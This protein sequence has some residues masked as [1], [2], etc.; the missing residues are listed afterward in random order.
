MN[1]LCSAC[2]IPE[3]INFEARCGHLYHQN[4]IKELSWIELKCRVCSSKMTSS[5]T[6]EK[7][8]RCPSEDEQ[9]KFIESGLPTKDLQAALI[10]S[11][12]EQNI[13]LFNLLLDRLG[14]SGVSFTNEAEKTPL[15]FAAEVGNVEVVDRL[16]NMKAKV[17]AAEKHFGMTPLILACK[18][19]HSDVFDRLLESG[20]NLN[21]KCDHGK[22]P[23]HYVCMNGNLEIFNKL[24][25][26]GVNLEEEDDFGLRPLH[27]ICKRGHYIYA[28][29]GKQSQES[30]KIS[31]VGHHSQIFDRLLELGVDINAVS[32]KDPSK[33]TPLILACEDGDLDR[34]DKL[35]S[36][37]AKLDL[38]KLLPAACSGGG[39][40]I[41][42]K[43]IESGADV[44][45]R[46]ERGQTPMFYIIFYY[47]LA[48]ASDKNAVTAD[49]YLKI[50]DRL[51]EL[52]ADVNARDNDGSTCLHSAVKF[53]IG[54]FS[55]I[56]KLLDLGA[57]V[58]AKDSLGRTPTSLSFS[59]ST[60][61]FMIK[62]GGFVSASI[63]KPK[64]WSWC[65]F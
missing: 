64:S 16:L 37:G 47:F 18:M 10:F 31:T 53:C 13:I 2:N 57:D 65:C 45:S 55:L 24:V 5:N 48:Q 19:G 50:L 49:D 33:S 4:C 27:Y 59:K 20:A 7:L 34:F 23:I 21:I 36:L 26:L 17:N 42:N 41:F 25:K 11:I 30:F 38:N 62:R 52:G 15:H 28:T 54:D 6:F 35:L 3:K 8:L 39:I 58:N 12:K 43:L 29:R 63:L 44:N 46:D 51:V 56:E 61:D 22:W 60:I 1:P 40:E 14:S 9:K 32:N